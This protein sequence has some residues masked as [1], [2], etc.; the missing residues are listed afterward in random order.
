[1]SGTAVKR[2]KSLKNTDS[3]CPNRHSAP[4]ESHL[5]QCTIGIKATAPGNNVKRSPSLSVV[6]EARRKMRQST[7]PLP[8]PEKKGS[9]TELK[10]AQRVL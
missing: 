5:K 9:E 1:M 4:A 6:V 7:D 8:P 10:N 2:R 3:S